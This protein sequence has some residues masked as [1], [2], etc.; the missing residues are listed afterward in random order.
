M[1]ILTRNLKQ[2]YSYEFSKRILNENELQKWKDEGWS[3]LPQKKSPIDDIVY[4]MHRLILYS[5]L[6]LDDDLLDS[7]MIAMG[8]LKELVSVKNA[9]MEAENEMEAEIYTKLLKTSIDF[10]SNEILLDIQFKNEVK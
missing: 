6:H 3:F 5:R 8:N 7:Y 1:R 4:S 9:Q 2:D 10:V